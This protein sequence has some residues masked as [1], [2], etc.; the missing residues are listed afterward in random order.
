MGKCTDADIRSSQLIA[1]DRV[2]IFAID[3]EQFADWY[4][5]LL[6]N[7]SKVRITSIQAYAGSV[8]Y[9]L[10]VCCENLAGTL[11]AQHPVCQLE[12]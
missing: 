8:N 1:F 2:A 7:L 9:R 12:P 4:E 6:L 10:R 11:V 3:V 5:Y